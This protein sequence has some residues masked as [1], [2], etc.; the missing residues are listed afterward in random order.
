MANILMVSLDQDLVEGKLG[1]LEATFDSVHICKDRDDFRSDAIS[2]G[3]NVVGLMIGAKE[4]VN[5][6]LVDRLPNLRVV[7]TLSTG[8]DHLDTD[9]LARRSVQVIDAKGINAGAVAEHAL[10]LALAA[11]KYVVAGNGAVW[12]GA[13]RAGLPSLPSQLAGKTVGIL[14]AGDTA[15]ELIRLLSPFG[16]DVR[17]WT[18]DPGAHHDLAAQE[19]VE[20]ASWDDVMTD[21]DVVSIH[22]PLT[23]DTRGRI[24]G[25]S[26]MQMR[27][28]AVLVN[29]SR[30]ALMEVKS[31]NAALNSRADVRL[32]IDATDLRDQF[33]DDVSN[34]ILASPH[35]AGV[36]LEIA[37]Q[38]RDHV[39]AGI[40]DWYRR[41]DAE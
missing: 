23:D 3:D 38:M 13:D 34:G 37:P 22:L 14:G 35:V 21:S 28:N 17:V 11:L 20:F 30:T 18:R 1:L 41:S 5:S 32:C 25:D 9:A 26:I 4:K 6:D 36:T 33:G 19:N 7:G 16:C 2:L 24:D 29:T 8:R 39:I 31:V 10:T 27:A 12:S 15:S 40:V